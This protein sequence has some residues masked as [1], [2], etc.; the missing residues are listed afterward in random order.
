MNL[1][2]RFKK[3]QPK[4][5]TTEPGIDGDKRLEAKKPP[6]PETDY[7]P[8]SIPEEA[9]AKAPCRLCSKV[10]AQGRSGE[11][12]IKF[13]DGDTA[14]VEIVNQSGVDGR[15]CYSLFVQNE[16]E[17]GFTEMPIKYC[18]NCGASLRKPRKR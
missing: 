10:P 16:K 15:A 7:I 6:M 2:R 8:A 12:T 4:L 1:F 5:I 14:T 13:L 18:P 3:E 17:I 9:S 11:V